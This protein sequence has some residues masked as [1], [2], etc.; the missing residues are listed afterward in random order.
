MIRLVHPRQIQSPAPILGL[1]H[2]YFTGFSPYHTTK[3]Q[4]KQAN[5]T[6]KSNRFPAP[7]TAVFYRFPIPLPPIELKL[8]KPF[9]TPL[10]H[11]NRKIHR[12]ALTAEVSHIQST[13]A[14]PIRITPHR[15]AMK[16]Q[17]L[18]VKR[19]LLKKQRLLHHRHRFN[20]LGELIKQLVGK[21]QPQREVLV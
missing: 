18:P 4:S 13:L 19:V 16:H 2:P 7:I 3:I 14:Q 20:P 12:L 15:G 10:F 1:Y 17:F 6:I 11:P 5:N 9:F 8:R 21:Y